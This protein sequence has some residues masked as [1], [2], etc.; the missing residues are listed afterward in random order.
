MQREKS[1]K[2]K[3]VI[4]SLCELLSSLGVECVPCAETFRRAKFNKEGDA[5]VQF[6]KLLHNVLF[7]TLILECSCQRQSD[8]ESQSRHVRGALWQCGYG[9]SW[10]VG[11]D[12]DCHPSEVGS[13]DLLLA[14]G[15]VLSSGNLL[16]IMLKA[17]AL[18]LDSLSLLTT[19]SLGITKDE[20]SPGD[21]TGR[22]SLQERA[23]MQTDE[24]LLRRLQWHYGKLRFRWRSLLT[25]QEERA[26]ILHQVLS[27][28]R[29]HSTSQ[30][31]Q[32]EAHRGSSAVLRKEMDHVRTVCHLLEAY[33]E[34]KNQETLFW[35]WMDSVLDCQLSDQRSEDTV[36][37][38]TPVHQ[39][40][41]RS[42]SHGDQERGKLERSDGLLQRLQTE[43]RD[44]R[45]TLTT[46]SRKAWRTVP[47]VEK[48]EEIERRVALKLRALA[49]S[50]ASTSPSD[51][52][53]YRPMLRVPQPRS[54]QQPRRL[55]TIGPVACD[56]AVLP[57]REAGMARVQIQAS[58]LIRE[59]Q[60]RED[61]LLGELAQMRQARREEIQGLT[62]SRLE[63]VGV[64]L[65]PPVLLKR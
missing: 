8:L 11:Q 9:A 29:T 49:E 10:V 63:G 41:D 55:E 33:L 13:R 46:Q 4:E 52:T 2:A 19:V 43:L 27:V 20:G 17:R 57:G 31:S 5:V 36:E 65:I 1:V 50:Y 26:R 60:Q 23:V 62:A 25:V 35:S 24:W 32:C 64:V 18:E 38:M 14:F 39:V 40:V 7:K 48:L 42:R 34:W 56:G 21:V 44:A 47:D 37:D 59:L 3:E 45:E 22:E 54:S 15:W 6:W 16:E 30:L 53:A 61:V 12:P 58:S 28:D 51:H